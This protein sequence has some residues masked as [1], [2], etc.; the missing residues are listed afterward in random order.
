M[1]HPPLLRSHSSVFL[2]LPVT[3]TEPIQ[4]VIDLEAHPLGPRSE[5]MSYHRHFIVP[6]YD[7]L[8]VLT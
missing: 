5:R 3:M 8:T 2:F 6:D 7:L 1:L 4:Q